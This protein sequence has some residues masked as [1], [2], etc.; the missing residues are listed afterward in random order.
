MIP[1]FAF[2]RMGRWERA[3]A[4]TTYGMALLFKGRAIMALGICYGSGNGIGNRYTY[5][6]SS[7]DYDISNL[8]FLFYVQE[9][10]R[11]VFLLFLFLRGR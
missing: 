6:H 11:D 10:C 3:L 1:V 2:P 8:E 9:I 5:G 4:I 7:I